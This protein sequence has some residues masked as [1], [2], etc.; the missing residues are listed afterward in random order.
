MK[1]LNQVATGIAP[2]GIRRLMERASQFDDVISLG[3]GEPDFP[4][5]ACVLEAVIQSVQEGNTG[6]TPNAG[7]PELRTLIAEHLQNRDGL[8]YDPMCQI[9]VTAGVS[10]AMDLTIRALINPGDEV[11][12]IEPTFVSYIPVIRLAGGVP[13][14]IA[15]TPGR[16]FR[17]PAEDVA[18]A[19][20]SNTKAMIVCDPNN[21]TGVVEDLE[22]LQ[23]IRDLAVQ[24]R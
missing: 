24:G 7:L 15:A 12:I 10:E 2:S 11:I 4:P 1:S 13:V 14:V 20:T 8:C 18:A 6:Y 21:P 9:L 19:I 16:G 3:I 22:T 17:I 23:A 5:P